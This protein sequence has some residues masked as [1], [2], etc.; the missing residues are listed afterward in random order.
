MR[1]ITVC[2]NCHNIPITKIKVLK[3]ISQLRSIQSFFIVRE[4]SCHICKDKI[5]KPVKYIEKFISSPTSVKSSANKRRTSTLK[6][7]EKPQGKKNEKKKEIDK[8]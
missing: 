8:S 3:Y 1:S 5:E 6:I 7:V 2:M 4:V